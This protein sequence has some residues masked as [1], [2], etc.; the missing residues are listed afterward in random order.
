MKKTNTMSQTH[1]IIIVL[2]WINLLIGLAG[3][4][5]EDGAIKLEKL[6]AGGQENFQ[7]IMA[8]Y[9]SDV[10][11]QQQ[12][13]NIDLML[14]Q[15]AQVWDT[16]A[17]SVDQAQAQPEPAQGNV[18]AADQSIQEAIQQIRAE[19]HI[20][21]NPNARYTLVEYSDLECP[22]CKRHH[23]NGTAKALLERFPNDINHAFRHFP[24]QFHANARMAAEWLE[25]AADIN[26]SDAF[27]DMIA[28]IFELNSINRDG[29]ISAASQLGIDTTS[30]TECLD[31]GRFSQKVSNQLN[32]WQSLFGISGTPGNV[33]VDSET[34]RFVVVAGAFP[35]DRFVQELET[36]I[37]NQ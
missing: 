20:Q 26:G 24:L 23:Q 28:Q 35:V 31:S 6:R 11:K 34:G 15:A 13:Q 25:C 5:R 4:L 22:F 18:V 21:G 27:Y 3:L 19:G 12:S 2:L 32:E 36:L 14:Q 8:Y 37:A 1:L 30:F 10:F 29:V 33:I 9:Q 7:K 16:I 17:P